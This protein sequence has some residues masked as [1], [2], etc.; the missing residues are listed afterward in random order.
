MTIKP[1]NVFEPRRFHIVARRAVD[2]MRKMAK[3]NQAGI[4]AFAERQLVHEIGYFLN[5]SFDWVV[6][7]QQYPSSKKLGDRRGIADIRA[8]YPGGDS[9][10]NEEIWVEVKSTGFT[11][12]H[13]WENG[14]SSFSWREDIIKQKSLDNR[15]QGSKHHC[16]WAWL[17]LF[18]THKPDVEKHFGR[19]QKWSAAQTAETMAGNFKMR[20]GD[21]VTLPV[22]LKRIHEVSPATM[23]SCLPGLADEEAKFSALLVTSKVR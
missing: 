2:R 1:E 6:F 23:V 17:Y 16:Y 14:F 13:R 9:Q 20:R 12:D 5:R 8:Y 11:P 15:I 22:L 7:E 10:S 4:N 18:Q 19:V 3:H 21:A